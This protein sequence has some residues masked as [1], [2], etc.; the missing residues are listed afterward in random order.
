MNIVHFLTKN[1]ISAQ[2]CLLVQGGRNVPPSE[3]PQQLVS[4]QLVADISSAFS[5]KIEKPKTGSS[6]SD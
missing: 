2:D 6:S 3:I 4:T 1:E 5:D